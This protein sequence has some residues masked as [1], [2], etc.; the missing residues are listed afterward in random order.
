MIFIKKQFIFEI[1]K[2]IFALNIIIYATIYTS[3]IFSVNRDEYVIK[4]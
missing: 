3:I 2:L 4:T 1:N